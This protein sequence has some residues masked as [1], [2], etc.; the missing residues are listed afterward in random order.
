LKRPVDRIIAKLG[1]PGLLDALARQLSGADF[2]S[3][4]LEVTQQRAA[5][6]RPAELLQRHAADRFVAPALATFASQRRVEDA[7][8]AAADDVE[9]V[10][11]APLVPLGTHSALA[12]VA[13]NKIVTTV[14]NNEVAADPTNALA[15]VAAQRRAEALA[16]DPK[17]T[18]RVRLGAFQRVVRAQQMAG[19]GRFAHFA[20][21]GML[22]A[23]RD[24]GALVFEREAAPSHLIVHTRALLALGATRIVVALTDFTGG[25]CAAIS[26]AC[27]AALNDLPNV[28]STDDPARASGT[29]YYSGFCFK[30]HAAFGSG[31]A[32][33]ET[34]DGGIVDWTQRLVGSVKERCFISG[35][36]IDRVALA[37]ARM[38]EQS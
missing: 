20:L 30:I 9:I 21:F 16:L 34:S 38:E 17:S 25:G 23:G 15:L 18:T 13:Q 32:P 8:L 4:M 19:A 37:V 28:T 36:G 2:T 10:S 14:R 3:L 7:L 26:A 31:E 24:T 5:R 35:L 6:I 27:R 12:T 1:V 33:M 11:L 29:G 22:S